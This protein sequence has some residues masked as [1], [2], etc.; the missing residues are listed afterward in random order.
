MTKSDLCCAA[1]EY[2]TLSDLGLQM[3][4]FMTKENWRNPGLKIL[5]CYIFWTPWS[6]GFS[7][8][9]RILLLQITDFADTRFIYY[10]FF[11]SHFFPL[12]LVKLSWNQNLFACTLFFL[13]I[14]FQKVNMQHFLKGQ[15]AWLS[16]AV[17]F[18]RLQVSLPSLDAQPFYVQ[19]WW[20]GSPG[21]R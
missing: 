1:W 9:L 6:I 2:R 12:D 21:R 4:A 19:I 10:H 17:K 13:V 18:P 7:N 20:N 5:F 11:I 16:A 15:E 8:S 14:M 3:W